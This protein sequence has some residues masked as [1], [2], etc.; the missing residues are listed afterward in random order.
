MD[1]LKQLIDSV[2]GIFYSVRFLWGQF[3]K[4]KGVILG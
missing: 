1:G 3:A 2:L 4:L